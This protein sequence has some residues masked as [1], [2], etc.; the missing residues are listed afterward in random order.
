MR[1]LINRARRAIYR[2]KSE[3]CYC[4]YDNLYL[5]GWR[6]PTDCPTCG[7]PTE[8]IGKGNYFFKLSTF[9]GRLQALYRNK[10]DF[11]QPSFRFDE[12]KRIVEGGLNDIPMGRKTIESR[13]PVAR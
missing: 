2:R 4:L 11:V 10:P 7:R 9:K 6:A 3:G 12:V 8:F 5:N 13:I 1:R